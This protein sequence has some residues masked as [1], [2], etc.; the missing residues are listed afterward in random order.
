VP[1]GSSAPRADT[2]VIVEHAPVGEIPPRCEAIGDGAGIFRPDATSAVVVAPQ[3]R[4]WVAT[5]QE[6]WKVV[7]GYDTSPRHA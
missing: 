1:C 7:S 5:P 3:D 6:P 2:S 4:T